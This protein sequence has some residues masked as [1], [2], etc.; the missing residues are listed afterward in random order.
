M[1][2]MAFV[3]LSEGIRYWR[4]KNNRFLV[5]QFKLLKKENRKLASLILQNSSKQIAH[6]QRKATV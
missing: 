1:P 6:T 5:S 2:M 4:N 3:L